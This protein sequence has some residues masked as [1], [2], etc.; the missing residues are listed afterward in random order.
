MRRCYLRS[1]LRRCR[2][3]AYIGSSGTRTDAGIVDRST[4]VDANRSQMIDAAE[5]GGARFA[6]PDLRSP[7]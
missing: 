3:A 7:R 2:S 6:L 5:C 1:R 4:G